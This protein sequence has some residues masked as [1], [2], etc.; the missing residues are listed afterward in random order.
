MSKSHGNGY[1]Y[2]CENWCKE[3]AYKRSTERH[4][5][6]CGRQKPEVICEKFKEHVGNEMRPT[7]C[8]ILF[9]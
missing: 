2:K 1:K 9:M 8:L 7:G 4:V 3:Y 6:V 5:A